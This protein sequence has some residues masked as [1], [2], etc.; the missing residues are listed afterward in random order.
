MFSSKLVEK[1]PRLVFVGLLM[2]YA[3]LCVVGF[4]L[5]WKIGNIFS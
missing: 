4:V 3:V 2:I 1:Y 5:G